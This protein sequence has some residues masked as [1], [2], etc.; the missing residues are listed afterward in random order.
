MGSQASATVDSRPVPT[1]PR[2]RRVDRLI[3][4]I[5]WTASLVSAIA[6]IAMMF[7]MV[8]DVVLRLQ[9]GQPIPGAY[10][11]VQVLVVLIVFLGLAHSER[12]GHTIRV[13][14]LTSVLPTRTADTVRGIGRLLTV[15]IAIWLTWATALAAMDSFQRDEFTRAL[16]DFPVWPAKALVFVGCALLTIELIANLLTSSSSSSSS[17]A[18]AQHPRGVGQ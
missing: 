15:L 8:G 16:V 17:S 1:A 10:E 13:T 6:I 14:V 5:S 7:L 4:R 9:T 12:A 11:T 3:G 18:E 2:L